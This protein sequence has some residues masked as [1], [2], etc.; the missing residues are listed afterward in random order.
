MRTFEGIMKIKWYKN[1]NGDWRG[2][3]IDTENRKTLNIELKRIK[4]A[5]MTEQD[6]ESDEN[7]LAYSVTFEMS[8][9][10]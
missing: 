2:I 4:K 1:D 8:E 3:T 10:K 6:P 5:F 9:R 7:R